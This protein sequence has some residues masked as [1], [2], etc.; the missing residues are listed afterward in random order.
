MDTTE[1][2]GMADTSKLVMMLVTTGETDDSQYFEYRPAFFGPVV[3]VEWDKDT[4]FAALAAD[5]A[6]NLVF[7]GYARPVSDPEVEAYTEPAPAELPPP[8]PA[9]EAPV[10]TKKGDKS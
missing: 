8:P 10:R 3:R 9:P 2:G 7:N 4:M 5:T 1:A 6:D